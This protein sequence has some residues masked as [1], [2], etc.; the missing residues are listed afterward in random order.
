M[1]GFIYW[2]SSLSLTEA[3]ALAGFATA[4]AGLGM[5]TFQVRLLVRQLRLDAMLRIAESSRGFTTVS[6]RHPELWEAM[7]TGQ[8]QPGAE[9]LRR[10]RFIQLW[11][12]HAVVVWKC[13]RTGMLESGD[14]E[15]C[16]RDMATILAMPAV[17]E[18]WQ[19][20]REF[21]PGAFQKELAS[22]NDGPDSAVN[23]S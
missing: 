7:T 3:V 15:A 12:N 20:V 22:V 6:I 13:W 11:L 18:E 8:H 17:R 4:L 2:L 14:W 1:V 16:R 5:N 10:D 23:G 9:D 19:R 21:Y